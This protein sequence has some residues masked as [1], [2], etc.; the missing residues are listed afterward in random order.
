MLWMGGKLDAFVAGAQKMVELDPDD[1]YSFARRFAIEVF[2]WPGEAGVA[3]GTGRRCEGLRAA[4]DYV[5]KRIIP[6]LQE[7]QQRK[8]HVEQALR[9]ELDSND[10]S[11]SLEERL[12]AAMQ[13]SEVLRRLYGFAYPKVLEA[14]IARILVQLHRQYG[15][16]DPRLQGL[17]GLHGGPEDE[18]V[19]L[20]AE[21]Q[22]RESM[23][24]AFKVL[25]QS[26]DPPKSRPDSLS[27]EAH[28]ISEELYTAGGGGEESSSQA[29]G[30]RAQ[31]TFNS[32]VQAVRDLLDRIESKWRIFSDFERRPERPAAAVRE[33]VKALREE[34]EELDLG[35]P[36]A[37]EIIEMEL[38][39]SR[40]ERLWRWIRRQTG[41]PVEE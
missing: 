32:S 34:L 26:L 9:L 2:E 7:W 40:R 11:K 28:R 39:L 20:P 25:V 33:Y 38:P 14:R 17:A 29:L 30:V 23:R 18:P 12:G 21:G 27:F 35:D 6:N 16:D 1:R 13:S 37:R 15:L 19:S 10:V 41:R 36:A 4:L 24:E 8:A 3:E 22:M 5:Q 31:E